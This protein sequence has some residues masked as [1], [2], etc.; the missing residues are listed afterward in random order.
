LALWF[1]LRQIVQPMRALE[2][3]A[4]DLARGDFKSIRQPV[5]GVGEIR[6]L[7]S[8]L[9]DMATQ[10]KEAQNSLHSYIGAITDSVEN[11]RRN[12]ARELHDET[13]QTMIALGQY[14]QYAL[15]WNSDPKVEKTLNQVVELTDQGTQ[16]L[17]RLV[18]GLRPIYIEDLGLVTALGMQASQPDQPGG[19]E[20]HF[21]SSGEERRLK[22]EVE[23]AL[24]R[25]AQEALSNIR[26]HAG[27]AHAWIRLHFAP[28]EVVLEVR[29]DGRGFSMPPDPLQ[30]ARQGHYGLL[31]LH[32]R[33][34][35]IGATLSIHSEE[36]HGTTIRIRLSG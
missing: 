34:E 6:H 20:V 30:L 8:T 15:H 13:L 14:T 21:E 19:V 7:Q 26:R 24:Y 2:E 25:M 32:E 9:A 18:R 35:L 17:R 27:A 22:P 12:L 33:A 28:G 31:G 4:A 1:G 29:D 5:G 23:M 16:T 3:K 36:G 10:L 11:E